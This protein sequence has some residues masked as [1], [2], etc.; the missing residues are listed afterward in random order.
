[1]HIKVIKPLLLY[2]KTQN[3][4]NFAGKLLKPPD[5]KLTM[6]PKS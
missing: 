1:M 3:G 4:D 6:R 2:I 5:K